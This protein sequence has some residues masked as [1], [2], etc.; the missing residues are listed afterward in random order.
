MAV[1][2]YNGILLSNKKEWNSKC[3][4]QRAW[5]LRIIVRI[6]LD[7]I[8]VEMKLICGYTSRIGECLG[9]ACRDQ[10]RNFVVMVY[11]A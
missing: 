7:D 1:D 11:R 4:Q 9:S 6:H 3:I 8:L 10:Q 2:P 5:K